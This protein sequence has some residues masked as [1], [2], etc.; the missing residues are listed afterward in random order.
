[1]AEF[2]PAYDKMML[3]EGGYVLHT[4]KGDTGGQTY[5]GISRRANPGWVGWRE[6][7]RGEVPAAQQV[8]EFYR[9][10]YW[11][12]LRLDEVPSQEIASSIFNFGVNAGTKTAGKLAQIVVGVT[13]D[14]VF[15]SQTLGALI[16][17]D[18]A[19]FI[20]RYALAKIARYAEICNKNRAQSKFLLGWIN[21]TMKGLT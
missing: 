9:A 18:P 5:A 17:A 11:N 13:P 1:M 21:R 6:I 4:V 15:G 10:N 20:P 8:F 12:P 14:G 19:L 16:M 2:T 3:D 7:D